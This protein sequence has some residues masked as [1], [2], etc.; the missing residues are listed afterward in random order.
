MDDSDE[1]ASKKQRESI[2]SNTQD[3]E[4]DFYSATN[5]NPVLSVEA[6]EI[7]EADCQLGLD[8]TLN[9]H[10]FY[11]KTRALQRHYLDAAF[12]EQIQKFTWL[13]NVSTII[14][15]PV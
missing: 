14:F 12:S 1:P 3:Y 6:K 8:K 5:Y 2:K 13:I 4:L 15:F 7:A 9:E 11:I 10:N